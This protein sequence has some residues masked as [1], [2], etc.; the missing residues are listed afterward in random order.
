VRFRVY[1]TTLGGKE[2]ESGDFDFPIVVCEGC[3]VSYPASA[4][5][6]NSPPGQYLC[7]STAETTEE[8]RICFFGQDQRF[9]CTMCAGFDPIC[10]DPAQNPWNQQ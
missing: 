2:I 7:G 5:D 3:L 8:E 4:L 9:S 10:R 6:P 1:G